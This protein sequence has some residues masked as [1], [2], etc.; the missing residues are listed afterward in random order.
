LIEHKVFFEDT[1]CQWQFDVKFLSG[2]STQLET[3]NV[4]NIY[5]NIAGPSSSGGFGRQ[6][7]LTW[8]IT[9]NIKYLTINKQP[10]TDLSGS[11]LSGSDLSGS[12]LS[13]SD[14]SGSDLSGSDLSGTSSSYILAPDPS[15]VTYKFSDYICYPGSLA[16]DVSASTIWITG[17]NCGLGLPKYSIVNSWQSLANFPDYPA[18]NEGFVKCFITPSANNFKIGYEPINNRLIFYKTSM[19]IF[20]IQPQDI[21]S[22]AGYPI[23]E[24]HVTIDLYW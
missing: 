16:L 12:D 3:G 23:N 19:D 22:T 14:L 9:L 8:G 4:Y 13:G 20:N 18:G 2:P 24:P 11:D 7:G 5:F 10:G 21:D 17:L 15:G 1:P 6:L